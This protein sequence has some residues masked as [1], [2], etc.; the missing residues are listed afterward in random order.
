M[1]AVH[2]ALLE[3]NMHSS[4]VS[5]FRE[6]QFKRIS[7]LCTMHR[8]EYYSHL[9]EERESQAVPTPTIQLAGELP[10]L[11]RSFRGWWSTRDRCLPADLPQRDLKG[12]KCI[13][14]P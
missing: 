4:V 8:V 5:E 2:L 3:Y 14:K 7:R 6:E 13:L 10:R 11:V 12:E 9:K 1:A